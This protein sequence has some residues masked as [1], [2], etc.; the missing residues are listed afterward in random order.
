MKNRTLMILA[1]LITAAISLILTSAPTVTIA[2]VRDPQ[3]AIIVSLGNSQA[4]WNDHTQSIGIAQRA[5]RKAA[6]SKRRIALLLTDLPA[7]IYAVLALL[8]QDPICGAIP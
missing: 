3:G 8:D 6:E 5:A 2:L 1:L 7:D 4:A